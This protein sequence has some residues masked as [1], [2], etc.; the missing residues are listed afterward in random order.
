[1]TS[2]AEARLW[3]AQRVSAMVLAVCVL[4]HL[5]VIVYASRQ[6]LTAAQILGRTRGNVAFA[7]FYSAFVLACAIHVPIGLKAIAVEWLRWRGRSVGIAALV[8]ALAI[9]VMGLRAV[10]AVFV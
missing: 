1:M 8:V 2:A 10:Y 3:Y 7:A 9:L 5:A 6:G 4:V